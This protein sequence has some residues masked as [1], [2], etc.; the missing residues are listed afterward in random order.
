M[1]ASNSCQKI[2][3]YLHHQLP[4][5]P[6]E[7][8]LDNLFVQE[9]AEDFSDVDILEEI[10]AFRWYYNNDPVQKVSNVRIA[11][12]RWVGKAFSRAYS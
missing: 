5:Y 11:I 9:L 10:K 3:D 4:E 8:D 1:F 6:F 7:P 12:R 2:L